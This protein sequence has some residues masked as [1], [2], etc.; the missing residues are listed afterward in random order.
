MTVGVNS[1]AIRSATSY[2]AATAVRNSLPDAPPISAAVSAAG[3]IAMPGWV[4]IRKVSHLPPAKIVSALTKA[5]PALV[6]LAPWRRTG[7]GPP[8]ASFLLLHQSQRLAAC[9]RIVGN[10]RRTQRL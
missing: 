4:S 7:A 3:R 1:A 2:P 9:G 10:Q 8:A 6:I 5:A